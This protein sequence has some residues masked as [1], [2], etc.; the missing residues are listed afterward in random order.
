MI[1]KIDLIDE[2][3]YLLQVKVSLQEQIDERD[4]IIT[5]L[6]RRLAECM[7]QHEMETDAR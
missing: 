7:M 5:C 4:A 6:Q 2:N 1:K 3:F